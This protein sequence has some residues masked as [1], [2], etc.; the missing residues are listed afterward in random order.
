LKSSAE[1]EKVPLEN[2][3][4]QRKI[5]IFVGKQSRPP[6]KSKLQLENQNISRRIKTSAEFSDLRLKIQ[7][8]S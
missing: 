1:K 8:F 5:Q 6:R 7:K 4:V 2:R 3:K